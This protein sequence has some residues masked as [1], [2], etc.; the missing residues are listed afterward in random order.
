M[1]KYCRA[2]QA[3]DDN[4]V[5]THCMLDTQGDKYTLTICNTCCFSTAPMVAQ[6]D[7][8]VTLY[9]HCLSCYLCLDLLSGLFL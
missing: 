2:G 9:V 3:T 7:L 4:T 6:T 1:E 5:H 8:N